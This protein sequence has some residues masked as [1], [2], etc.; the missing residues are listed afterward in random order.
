MSR[1]VQDVIEHL[2]SLPPFPRV[3][4]KL[5][6]LLND[7]A[8]TVDE[9]TAVIS[10]EPSLVMK[11]IHMANSTFYMGSQ[12][13][14]SVKRAIFVLGLR[15]IKT[16]T[17]AASVHEGLSQYKPREDVF[18][19]RDFWKHSYAT[20]IA[21]NRL[22]DACCPA[23]KDRLYLAGLIHDIGKIIMAYYWPESWK[24]V[25]SLMRSEH[26]SF[27]AMELRAF[28]MTHAEMAATLCRSWHFPADIVDLIEKHH[29]PN[30]PEN[31]IAETN[32]M[33]LLVN[34]IVD[35]KGLAFPKEAPA[36][37][38]ADLTQYARQV[39]NLAD[40]VELFLQNSGTQDK[41]SHVQA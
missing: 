3:T 32:K 36:E 7:P 26:Q 22:A 27:A 12:P 11:V 9:Y 20:A 34:R 33:L 38:Y 13:V 8:V 5:M 15:T 25:L 40:D 6:A 2:S 35:S 30:T 10:A 14:D 39:G 4:T 29:Q 37:D 19:Y 16:I 23:D 1:S 17:A 41:H 28:K 31:P 24:Q 18:N 21:A